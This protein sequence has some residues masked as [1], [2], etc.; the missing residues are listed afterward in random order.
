MRI[1]RWVHD[2]QGVRQ[3]RVIGG[4]FYQGPLSE[5]WTFSAAPAHLRDR[6][7]P[8]TI[9]YARRTLTGWLSAVLAAGLIIEAIAEPHADERTAAA[10]P[11]VAGT[12]IAPYCLIVRARKP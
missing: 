1:G 8:F 9:T 7:R 3:A 10:H 4:Y 6:H 12:R 5:T 11:E 2:D